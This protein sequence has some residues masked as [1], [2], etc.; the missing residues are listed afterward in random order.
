MMM[1]RIHEA[2]AGFLE[3][4]FTLRHILKPFLHDFD[5]TRGSATKL[6]GS[7]VSCFYL[8]PSAETAEATGLHKELLLVHSPYTT[9]EPR[10]FQIAARLLGE[11]KALGRIEQIAFLVVSPAPNLHDALSVLGT[12]A[13][14]SRFAVPFG[15]GECKLA[16]DPFFV[17]K[18][19]QQSLFAR[20]LFDVTQPITNDVYFFGRATLVMELRDT[21]TQSENIGLFGLRKTG[22][23]SL[24][25][26]LQ[27]LVEQDN[28]GHLIYVDLQETR[29][30]SLRWFEL[31]DEL[32]LRIPNQAPK[33]RLNEKT[34]PKYFRQAIE[35]V[36]K[37]FPGN[38]YV[39]A[40]DEIEHITPRLRMCEHWDEDFL[41]FWKTI[42]AVQNA[43]RHVS[44]MVAGVNASVIETAV[45]KGHD[46][47]LFSLV[48][49][50]YLPT[51]SP[52]ELRQMI[53][54]L[55]GYMGL[56]FNDEAH[57]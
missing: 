16:T 54:T 28:L 52:Q 13:T 43:N 8:K 32:R 33:A 9:L 20:D 39:F 11:N 57:A 4:N 17:R 21:I 15:E 25:L 37:K 51:F 50:R 49:S 5:V 12:E 23:T 44:F 27:R 36:A 10:I 6:F 22:K 7:R 14:Q 45:F 30:Y 2:V 56:Q 29:L 42:R 35:E 18:R 38:R 24:T 47:P 19:L 26:K 46:N 41:H 40:L 3:S 55:G 1:G 31:L 48:R 34:G 53:E